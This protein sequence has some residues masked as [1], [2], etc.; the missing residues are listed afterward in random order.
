MLS[1][2][3]F[4]EDASALLYLF[5]FL[6]SGVYALVLWVQSGISAT[7]PPEVY[8]S[9]TRDPYLFIAGISAV[10]L[11]LSLEVRAEA[12]TN[13]KGRLETLGNELQA[14][15]VASLF[16]LILSALYA[17]S[18]NVS[19]A[20]SD[21][22]VGRFGLIF[23]ALLVLLS[24]L[25]TAKFDFGPLRTRKGLGVV[26]MLLVPAVLYGVGRRSP[27]VGAAVALVLGVL[28]VLLF[29]GDGLLGRKSE[30]KA[31]EK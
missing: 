13:R 7:L 4:A 20:A 19:G 31:Q 9:V 8:L 27:A 2:R 18:L 14:M 11:G 25:V 3:S 22:L 5:P 24:Y 28:G 16:L 1:S 10:L 30:P 12:P 26:A 17:N 29:V 23:P 21:L 6:A 15:A